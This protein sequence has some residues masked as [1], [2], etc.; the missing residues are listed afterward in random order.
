MRARQGI[1]LCIAA[2]LS[3]QSAC[4]QA[5]KEGAAEETPAMAE[6]QASEAGEWISLFDGT[7]FEGWKGYNQEG[8]PETW[9]IEDGAMVFTPPEERPQGANYN[10][11]TEGTYT[12][13]VLSLE[14]RIG[15]GGNSGVFWGVEEGEQF[16]QPYLTGPE[17]QVL[18]NQRHPDAKAGTT[19]QAGALYD[20]VA[21]AADVTRPVGEWNLMVI[22]VDY[23]NQQGS[24]DLNGTRIVEFPLGNQAWDTMVAGSKF[25]GWEGFGKYPSGKLGVQDHGDPVAFRNIKIKPL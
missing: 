21:P 15:E 3:L 24:V 14:W 13:F 18:D 1:G 2:V 19:H 5:P 23:A 4:R 11:V 17:I 22:T 10:L 20:M 16:G 7:S 9:S 8:V 12:N 25:A 6:A